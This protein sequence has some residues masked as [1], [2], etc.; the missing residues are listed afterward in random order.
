A[1][2]LTRSARARGV[3]RMIGPGTVTAR[4]VAGRESRIGE[5]YA[6]LDHIIFA[7]PADVKLRRF[8]ASRANVS[9]TSSAW[10]SA[11][12]SPPVPGRRL[13][14]G[15]RRSMVDRGRRYVAMI[16]ATVT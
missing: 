14:V 16:S 5:H 11:S 10:Y 4:T 7:R 15:A 6:D 9:A 3:D 13:S 2:V 1:A 8:A 12:R